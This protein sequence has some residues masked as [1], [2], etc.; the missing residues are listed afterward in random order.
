MNVVVFWVRGA[1]RVFPRETWDRL[2]GPKPPE[3]FVTDGCSISPDWIA[4]RPVW[5]ACVIHDWQYSISGLGVSRW[6]ADWILFRNL[7]RLLRI[8]GLFFGAAFVASLTYWWAVR[9]R[10]RDAYTGGE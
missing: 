10:A 9:T 2:I 6:R 1:P 7:Y 5:P 4:D 8:G 3:N